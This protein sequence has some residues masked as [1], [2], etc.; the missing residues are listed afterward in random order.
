MCGVPQ[1]DRGPNFTLSALWVDSA[2]MI[3]P[4]NISTQRTWQ[5]RFDSMLKTPGP[6]PLTR[7]ATYNRLM[8]FVIALSAA[9]LLLAGCG[10]QEQENHALP[11]KTATSQRDVARWAVANKREIESAISD[12]SQ[13]KMA[14][15]LNA[16]TLS[17]EETEQLRKYEALDSELMKIVT[18]RR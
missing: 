16:E 11:D 14:E 4:P 17:A 8:R 7:P 10:R 2:S 12:W 6:P 3:E 5:L 1:T 9:C 15:A 18:Q 13:A